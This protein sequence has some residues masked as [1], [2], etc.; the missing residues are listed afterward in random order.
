MSTQQEKKHRLFIQFKQVE[1]YMA[2]R[3][4]PRSMRH[5]ITDYYEHRYQGKIFDEDNILEE[6]SEKLRL[7]RRTC[8]CK[9]KD[10]CS[11]VWFYFRM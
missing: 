4:L 5:R 11:F 10:D 2:W 7:V 3:K 6:L 1:E 9:G 8:P